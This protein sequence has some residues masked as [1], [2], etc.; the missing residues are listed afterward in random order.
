VNTVA[1]KDIDLGP[2]KGLAVMAVIGVIAALLAIKACPSEPEFSPRTTAV[3]V[4]A[5]LAPTAEEKERHKKEL[6]DSRN[7]FAIEAQAGQVA[8]DMNTPANRKALARQLQQTAWRNGCE[9]KIEARGTTFYFEYVLIGRAFTFQFG[10]D[11]LNP[12]RDKF[13][14]LGFKKVTLTD[15]YENSWTWDL[16]S[17]ADLAAARRDRAAAERRAAAQQVEECS[18]QVYVGRPDNEIP[19]YCAELR[20]AKK[21]PVDMTP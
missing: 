21:Y 6:E 14:K 17:D 10:E 11:V 5:P 2:L 16:R 8:P 13:R 19:N 1:E 3:T 9:C 18:S 7:A 20:R 12:N 15:G 4:P